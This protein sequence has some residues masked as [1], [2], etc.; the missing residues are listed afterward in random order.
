[1]KQIIYIMFYLAALVPLLI[2]VEPSG[3]P[4]PLQATFACMSSPQ[5]S[6]CQSSN[7]SPET[8]IFERPGNPTDCRDAVFKFRCNFSNCRYECQFDSGIKYSCTSPTGFY[9]LAL[10]SHTFTVAA[11]SPSGVKDPSPWVYT[12]EIVDNVPPDTTITKHPVNPCG[13]SSANFEFTCNEASCTFQCQLDSCGW[14]SCTSPKNYSGLSDASHTFEVKAIDDQSMEDPTPASYTWVVDT[15]GEAP[16]CP[17]TPDT[18]PPDT[19]ISGSPADP[20]GSSSATFTFSCNEGNCT[21]DCQLDFGVWYPCASP[22]QYFNLSESGHAFAVR[23]WD[24]AGNMDPTP[25]I[26]IWTIH[27][28]D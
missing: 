12:W 21:Y 2:S 17:W 4:T 24:D 7:Q 13:S 19:T 22:A 9:N 28:A 6:S 1:M 15:G 14:S 3:T 16:P 10:G 18:T 5:G 25:V 23:A 20:S 26:Y 8:I 27:P 11:F